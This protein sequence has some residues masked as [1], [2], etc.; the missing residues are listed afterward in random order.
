MALVNYIGKDKVKIMPIVYI[1]ISVCMLTSFVLSEL[2][3]HWNERVCWDVLVMKTS[4]LTVENS[5]R[6]LKEILS[7][8]KWASWPGMVMAK[9]T[10]ISWVGKKP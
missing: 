5:G 3:S 7:W 1:Y 4:R 8:D 9:C 2:S 6:W 10:G